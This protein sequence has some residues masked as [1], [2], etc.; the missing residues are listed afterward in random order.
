MTMMH[1]M[2][3][4]EKY[5]VIY[6]QPVTV[7]FDM[8]ATYSSHFSGIQTTE[9]AWVA[10][11]RRRRKGHRLDRCARCACFKSMNAYDNA[12]GSVTIDLC[13]YS[14]MFERD[15]LGPFGDSL[16]RLERWT[17]TRW[18]ERQHSGD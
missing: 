3:L 2:S 7:N 12:D 8:F 1:D 10:A 18:L 4:T 5:V 16:A 13:N 17:L 14:K 9:I 6:D 15:L 11:K